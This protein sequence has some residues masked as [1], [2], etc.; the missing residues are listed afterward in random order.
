MS[1][2]DLVWCENELRDQRKVLKREIERAKKEQWK[3]LCER[4][5]EDVWGEEYRIALSSLK[6]GS[7]RMRWRRGRDER[8]LDGEWARF[9]LTRNREAG[10][11]FSRRGNWKE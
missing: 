4:L 8:S 11:G 5:E 9:I 6:A 7:F 3:R 1:A 2:E 10:T